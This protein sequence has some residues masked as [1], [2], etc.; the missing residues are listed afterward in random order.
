MGGWVWPNAYV[1]L[2]SGWVGLAKCLHNQKSN[3]EKL[4]SRKWWK[5]DQSVSKNKYNLLFIFFFF[6]DKTGHILKFMYLTILG[7]M[8]FPF[9]NA[10]TFLN[11]HRIFLINKTL[12]NLSKLW[13]ELEIMLICLFLYPYLIQKSYEILKEFPCQSGGSNMGPLACESEVL[14]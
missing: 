7:H 9:D 5:F 2:H 8:L 6:R 10:C 1:C 13:I 14:Y 4:I 12:A 11:K 3:T